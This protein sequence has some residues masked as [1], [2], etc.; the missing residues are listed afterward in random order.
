MQ[1]QR[2]DQSS[3]LSV[4]SVDKVVVLHYCTSF[5]QLFSIFKLSLTMLPMSNLQ[6]GTKTFGNRLLAQSQQHVN[7]EPVYQHYL[8][9]PTIIWK[10]TLHYDGK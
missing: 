7:H 4:F 8:N 2:I 5:A 9:C 10:C 1:L 6:S 3:P